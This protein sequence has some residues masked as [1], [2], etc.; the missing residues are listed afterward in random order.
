MVLVLF[1]GTRPG[2]VLVFVVGS[3]AEMP[4]DMSRI[5]EIITHDLERNH[6]SYYNDYAERTK[7][8]YRQ[9]IQKAW[10]QKAHRGSPPPQPRPGP[11]HPR[12]GAPWRQQ[13]GDADGR[14]RSG[15]TATFSLTT[16][17][18]GGYSAA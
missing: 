15:W 14:G 8:M 7:G 2:R 17:R 16:P 3:F 13:R 12:P 1:L 9:R 18:R 10:G 4:E 6:V 5:C 11:R